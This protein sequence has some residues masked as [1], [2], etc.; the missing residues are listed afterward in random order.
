MIQ[1]LVAWLCSWRGH[2]E[3]KEVRALWRSPGN[4][5]I[6]VLQ[7]GRCGVK[8]AYLRELKMP[9]TPPSLDSLESSLAI[10]KD[11]KIN[12]RKR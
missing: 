7:C 1:H 10:K 4:A 6:S 12:A 5:V 9:V 2:G 3:Y 8:F 11:G